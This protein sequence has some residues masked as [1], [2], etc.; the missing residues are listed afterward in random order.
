MIV[1]HSLWNL[2]GDGRMNFWAESSE[3][4]HAGRQRGN[5]RKHPFSEKFNSLMATIGR[6]ST[7]KIPDL[8]K[9]QI[10]RLYLPSSE[11]G[12]LPSGGIPSGDVTEKP[13]RMLPWKISSIGMSASD[14]MRFFM[15]LKKDMPED[16]VLGSSF[17]YWHE[18]LKL[19]IEF[20]SRQAF[21]PII[22]NDRKNI[23]RLYTGWRMYPSDQDLQRINQLKGMMPAI[24]LAS[25]ETFNAGYGGD[26]LHSFINGI[27]DAFVRDNS[28]VAWKSP[29]EENSLPHEFLRSLA[30]PDPK[31][32]VQGRDL[33]KFYGQIKSWLAPL[34][35]DG[36]SSPLRTC[37][38]VEEPAVDGDA[39]WRISFLLQAKN[40]PSLMIPASKIWETDSDMTRYINT[41]FEN[42]Q[43]RLL[44]DLGTASRFYPK[45]DTS[46]DEP[47]P[48]S[49]SLNTEDAYGFMK[50]ISPLLVGSGFGVQFPAWWR[51]PDGMASVRLKVS[52]MKGDT[53]TSSGLFGISSL[54]EFDWSV[55][56]GDTV[57]SGEDL[58]RLVEL[59]VPLIN[60][61][62]KW[63]E[64]RKEDLERAISFFEKKHDGHRMTV[65]E[66]LGIGL[67]SSS[68]E[69]GIPVGRL[70][71]D[72]WIGELL[73]RLGANEKMKLLGEPCG[74]SGK[75][76]PY[77]KRGA[78]WLSFLNGYGFGACLADDMGL[79]KTVQMIASFLHSSGDNGITGPSLLI[80]P[81][82]IVG[83]WGKELEK[84]SPNISFMVHHGAERITGKAFTEEAGKY[85][86][87]I[88]TY[89]LA[90]RDA[91]HI[92]GIQWKYLILD[93]AQNIKNPSTK[94]R[95]A[96][97]EFKASYRVA[98]TGTPIEN[99]LVEL[100]SIMDFLN[101]GYLGSLKS[102]GEEFVKPIER[103]RTKEKAEKLR[104]MV[105]P[106]ILRRLK[107]D[108]SI[109]RDLPK[110]MEMKVYC[111]LTS[112]QTSLY[113]STVIDMLEQIGS[114][115]GI[116][117][118]GLILSTIT[119]LKQICNHPAQFL[120]DRS[121]LENRSG[122]LNRLV[123]MLEE[124]IAEGDRSLVFTQ[125]AEMG[126][127][128]QTYIQEKLHC[129]VMFMY[130]GTSKDKRDLMVQRFQ[131]E[132]RGPPVF[133][134][135]LK[136]GGIGLNLTAA[137]R[138][139][140][141]D[142]WWN[143]AVENQA[144]DRVFR[145]GQKKNVQVH[146]FI[147]VATLEEKI[148]T[149]IEMKKDLAENIVGTGESWI[150]ELSTDQLREL[151]SIH[152]ERE[153]RR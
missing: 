95:R 14:T 48:E 102:F 43:E 117:R 52:P 65:G 34:D 84:F 152:R 80:C 51:K 147:S 5:A 57:L 6:L 88:T 4:F 62:G 18:A 105:S 101:P 23:S 7:D 42:A 74:F 93:E 40:D 100:W 26:L 73:G 153:V 36:R 133:V 123:E 103:L 107:T 31:I 44:E 3:L 118:R 130:G 68:S 58:R 116:E 70:E 86:L 122:K 50:D 135:S 47:T 110:K 33:S 32:E 106:F 59:K 129:D 55:A 8:R 27:I 143:P 16:I 11:H 87:V 149:L 137:S 127:M 19:A 1:V 64:V 81:M 148:D 138:V 67:G 134:L 82:S 146:K 125:Y 79:G 136:A 53:R 131:A 71:A 75:L 92:S 121:S 54:A 132:G 115:E 20:V 151:F 13:D 126:S 98:L 72:G 25:A 35:R 104:D 108:A 60:F 45:L 12:P 85:D 99:R 77:Q 111:N 109:I 37:F 41:S 141:F 46:L 21:A 90:Q 120:H 38:R 83:N 128:L 112:E 96:I 91:D 29:E 24:C 76:R 97:R 94:Q 89:A 30:S 61:R 113:E 78:S 15:G 144:T 150:T 10:I 124:A 49:V 142:R 69:T 119:K 66:A 145:I 63:A 56:I 39:F 140:H 17:R 28:H 114:S 2:E 9:G 139:F 22:F